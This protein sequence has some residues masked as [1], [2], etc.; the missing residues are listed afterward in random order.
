MSALNIGGD[1]LIALAIKHL[2]ANDHLVL[3]PIEKQGY[4]AW[5]LSMREAS[6][7]KPRKPK[8]AKA[9]APALNAVGKPFSPSYD[10]A[11]KMKYKGGRMAAWKPAT[12]N[13]N[14]YLAIMQAKHG[15][16][17]LPSWQRE[18]TS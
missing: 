2:E 7:A 9:A 12:P 6:K 13:F 16:D 17:W 18:A 3:G 10:P 14:A 11:Y 8:A 1:D 15:A 5:Q 4:Y